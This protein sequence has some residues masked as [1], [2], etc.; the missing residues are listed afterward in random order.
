MVDISPPQIKALMRYPILERGYAVDQS[1][2]LINKS[3]E[4]SPPAA[5]TEILEY[6]KKSAVRNA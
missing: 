5:K 3:R 2:L 6:L 1:P 4:V